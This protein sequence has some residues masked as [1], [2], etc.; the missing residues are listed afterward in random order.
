[1]A[2][3]WTVANRQ[4]LPLRLLPCCD[5]YRSLSID[6]VSR[7][8]RPTADRHCEPERLSRMRARQQLWELIRPARRGETPAGSARESSRRERSATRRLTWPA[9]RW[10]NRGGPRLTLFRKR[11]NPKGSYAYFL[12]HFSTCRQL[13]GSLRM[14]G[15]GPSL[16]LILFLPFL[17]LSSSLFSLPLP[18][19]P[20]CLVSVGKD[21][22]E[23][24]KTVTNNEHG[25][26]FLPLAGR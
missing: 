19:V 7:A 8:A 16:S 1:M 2:A 23:W 14:R 10:R 15:S 22:E 4:R 3:R 20:D 21:P 26:N 5:S 18:P 6:S 11:G 12:L 24:T 25:R 9:P 17:P 13:R